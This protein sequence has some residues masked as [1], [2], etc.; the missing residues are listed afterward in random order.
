[1]VLQATF[2]G[3][4]QGRKEGRLTAVLA[5]LVLAL[6][7]S[8]P[9]WS[10]PVDDG[11]SLDDAVKEAVAANPQVAS[12]KAQYEAA[13]HQIEQAYSPQDPQLSLQRTATPDG[14]AHAQAR[15]TVLSESFQFPGAAW[16]QGDEAHRAAEIARLTYQAAVRDARAGAETDYYQTLL[17]SASIGI[18]RENALSFAEVLEVARVAYTANQAAQTDLIGAQFSL[19]QASQ[20]VHSSEV[21]EAN[22]EAALNQVLG[23]DPQSE[24]ELSGSLELRPLEW[25]LDV[26]KERALKARQEL[27]EAALT[28]KNAQTAR[29]LAWMELLPSFTAA[30]TWN[31][32]PPGSTSSINAQGP[33]RDYSTSL[34][35]N[36]PVFFWFHQ[37][38]DIRAADRLLESARQN[39][40]SVELQ[41]QASV[42][43]LYRS[44]Q[45]AYQ[46]A[47]LYRDLLVPLALQDFR[48]GLIAY[49]S[50]KI[51]FLTL[52][53]ILQNVFSSRVSYLT[54]ANQFLAGRVALEQAMGGPVQ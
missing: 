28:E 33:Y 41:T 46:T 7:A 24:L 36:I 43:E 18:A 3:L 32:Y 6:G 29:A 12:A 50:Q 14:F 44:T 1:M 10:A 45:L 11:L 39:R 13:V 2:P 53:S 30:W 47:L 25:T 49:Q 23:R 31:S 22:D 15:S 34:T 52:S 42:V 9:A 19:S 48:V 38:E 4:V 21:A 40:R 8:A 26:V 5:G 37:K 17:D 16:L 54:A 20:S 35:F 51:D 27:L